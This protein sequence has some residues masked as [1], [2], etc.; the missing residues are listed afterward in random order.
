MLFLPFFQAMEPKLQLGKSRLPL[1]GKQGCRLL[2]LW[3]EGALQC[4]PLPGAGLNS[5]ALQQACFFCLDHFPVFSQCTQFMHGPL[6]TL[7]FSADRRWIAS[8]R[9]AA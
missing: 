4:Q 8:A 2:Q 5:H 7:A 9:C 3:F 1:G 6:L